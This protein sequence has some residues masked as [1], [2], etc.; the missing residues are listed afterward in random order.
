[1]TANFI[2]LSGLL[3]ATHSA[4][5]YRAGSTLTITASLNDLSGATPWSLL[6]HP[7]L[8]SGWSLTSVSGDGS[9]ELSPDG[10]EILFLS[11]LT[12]MPIDFSY[13]VT[14]P[15]DAQGSQV[16]GATVEYQNSTGGPELGPDGSILFL[17]NLTANPVQF[18]YQV[19]VP[20]GTSGPQ[21]LNAQ[22]EYQMAG[23]VN[24]QTL[25]AQP[26]PL[27]VGMNAGGDLI[28]AGVDV[29]SS[30]VKTFNACG[31][32]TVLGDVIV[33]NGVQVILKAGKR[34]TFQP[35]FKVNA[36]GRLSAG[37]GTSP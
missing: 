36:G 15:T 23:A 14:V 24:A 13:Q 35:G 8:P 37:I 25:S 4:S 5:S 12:G 1:M 30:G 20:A 32:I 33:R 18:T 7:I 6:W 2:A 22:V 28:I 34:I 26:S 11:S 29:P 19:S 21:N 27:V 17:G 10:S 31:K 16:V 3:N 9:P